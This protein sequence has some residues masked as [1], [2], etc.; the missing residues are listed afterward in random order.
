MSFELETIVAKARDMLLQLAKPNGSPSEKLL[1]LKPRDE[2]YDLVFATDAVAAARAGYAGL[3]AA[4]PPWPVKP[5]QTDLR[6]GAAYGSDFASDDPRTRPFPGGYK[7]ISAH[8]VPDRVWLVWEFVAPG[9]SDGIL[10]DGLVALPDH[11]AWF[12]KPW[13]VVPRPA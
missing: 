9:A 6:I 4:P 7:T 10:F 1:K 2:D 8:L 5:D 13:R 12:P 11:Y 3:W